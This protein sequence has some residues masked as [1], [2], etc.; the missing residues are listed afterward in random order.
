VIPNRFPDH[1]Y[2]AVFSPYGKMPLL[3]EEADEQ[4]E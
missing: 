4:K 2:P 3:T 1:I